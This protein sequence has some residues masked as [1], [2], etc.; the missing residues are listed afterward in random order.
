[1]CFMKH[2]KLIAYASRKIK[3]HK[4][5]CP[6]HDL[7]IGALVFALK[8]GSITC[9]LFMLMCVPTTRVSTMCLLKKEL[10]NKEGD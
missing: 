1:M 3:V 9:I 7:K 10:N 2:G 5:K 6:T 4:N 8:K